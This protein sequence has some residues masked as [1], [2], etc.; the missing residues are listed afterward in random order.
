MLNYDYVI[1]G[2]GIIGLSLAYEIVHSHPNASLAI[3]DKEKSEA[4]HASGRNS[5]VIHAGIYYASDSY[6]AKFCLEG[7]RL[8]KQFCRNKGLK[9]NE[10]GKLIVA[11][12][13]GELAKLHQLYHQAL[14]NG[15]NVKLIS[16]KQAQAIEPNVKTEQKALWS[17]ETASVDPNEICASL[18]SDLEQT[19]QADFFFNCRI[20]DI[21]WLKKT[22][23]GNGFAINYGKLINCAGLYAD[24]IADQFGL[25]EDVIMLPFKGLYLLDHQDQMHL[26]TNIYPVPDPALP[27][28]GIHFTVTVNN[29]TK[30]GPT[31]LP[32]LWR[33]QY[34]GLSRAD[35]QELIE[36][37]QWYLQTYWY[38]YFN[39]RSLVKTEFKYLFKAN[40][41][42]EGSR[43]INYSLKKSQFQT[44]PPGIRAQLYDRTNNKLVND[45]VIRS[46]KD[47]IHVLNAVSPAFTS[48]FTVAKHIV[49]HHLS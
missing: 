48:A 18:R 26:R 17:P 41:L 11:K 23:S 39:F 16:E 13:E 29:H 43:L 37:T 4:L 49:K 45:F 2:A 12:T 31:A 33:E 20:N 25:A 24:R 7:G 38:N 35:W 28:L 21:Q 32:A 6:K 15:T 30:I 47:S 14:T 36:I 44:T 8:L 27:F 19:G 22:L 34:Q 10:C 46:A 1:I 40:L 3:L 42:N 5:G 9:L